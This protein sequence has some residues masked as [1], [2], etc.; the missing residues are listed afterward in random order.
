MNKVKKMNQF[1]I[2]LSTLVGSSVM[3]LGIGNSSFPMMT[4]KKF[5]STEFTGTTTD[6]GGM[7]LQVRYTQKMN[8]QL[9][10]DAG[11]GIA[12]GDRSQRA[13][14]GADYELYPD[15]MQ[16]PKISLRTKLS[17]AQEFEKTKTIVSLAPTFSKG[18]NV[19]GNEAF[20]YVSIPLGLNL[21]SDE[22]T[23]ESTASL[24]LGVNGKLPIE[25][26]K[27]LNGNAEVQVGLKES[28]TAM[29]LG[30]SFPMN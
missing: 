7:G 3:A 18:F 24:N 8:P 9:T 28:Y 13:F 17:R 10:M 20:P 22:R 11:I 30:L 21:N 14:L 23:Y 1:I 16:Q 27:H 4:G 6:D 29:V 2:V 19:Y 15:Y 12:G 5:I 26:Y 25:G